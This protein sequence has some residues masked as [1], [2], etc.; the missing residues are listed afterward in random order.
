MLGRDEV[1]LLWDR[2][3]AVGDLSS[4]FGRE[5]QSFGPVPGLASGGKKRFCTQVGKY[6]GM[7]DWICQL[8]S[9][10]VLRRVI[11]H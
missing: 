8:S 3:V 4:H 10:S 2:D 9:S 5:M 1:L 6:M 7:A 11:F